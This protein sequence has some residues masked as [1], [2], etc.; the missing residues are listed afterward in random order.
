VIRE[1]GNERRQLGVITGI[2][3]HLDVGAQA[4]AARTTYGAP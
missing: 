3:A 4:M 1:P 2:I